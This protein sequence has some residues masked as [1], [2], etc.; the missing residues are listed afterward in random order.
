MTLMEIMVGL[1]LVAALLSVLFYFFHQ[2]ELL[3]L[4]SEKQRKEAFKKI[5]LHTRLANVI[6]HALG[7]YTGSKNK[8]VKH[9]YFFTDEDLGSILAPD[10]Q[11]LVFVYKTGANLDNERAGKS[12]GRLFVDK[13]K[14]L[15]LASWS[16][17]DVWEDSKLPDDANIEILMEEVEKLRFEFYV[18]PDR[19]RSKIESKNKTSKSALE[20]EIKDGW[21]SEWKREYYDLPP[22]IKIHVTHN[23]QSKDVTTFKL[24]LPN[25]KKV[26]I[27]E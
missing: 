15:C 7:E 25:S 6:P 17:P 21:T 3:N 12:L 19:D 5:Y 8:L 16:S 1:V 20:P 10:S 24:A 22:L 14:R 26:I 2:S 9:F 11:S 18:P 13:K 27:Y 23:S 4:Q